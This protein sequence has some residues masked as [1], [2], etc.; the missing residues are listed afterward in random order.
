MALS[1]TVPLVFLALMRSLFADGDLLACLALLWTATALRWGLWR[2]WST[3]G[4]G[5]AACVWTARYYA[6]AV[7]TAVAWSV[8]SLLL[9]VYRKLRC[10]R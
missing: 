3:T 10:Y 1:L 2:A 5:R 7:L 6:V 4:W 8:S 9:L